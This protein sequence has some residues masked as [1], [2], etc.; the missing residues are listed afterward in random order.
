MEMN[1][2]SGFPQETMGY[3]GLKIYIT[4]PPFPLEI[5]LYTAPDE[6]MVIT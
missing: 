5:Y 3:G 4:K 1:N 2:N 6:I